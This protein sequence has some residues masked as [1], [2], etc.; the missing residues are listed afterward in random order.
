MGDGYP[1]QDCR[2]TFFRTVEYI[3]PC[4]RVSANLY[5]DKSNNTGL[6]I[7]Q[8]L[9]QRENGLTLKDVADIYY[10]YDIKNNDNVSLPEPISLAHT[11]GYQMNLTYKELFTNKINNSFDTLVEI[12]GNIYDLSLFVNSSDLYPKYL[13]IVRQMIDTFQ[14]IP[15]EK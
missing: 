8:I 7:N 11:D 12:H 1:S 14:E 3:A 5:A 15:I 10:D 2:G 13:P 9:N 4:L 6:S